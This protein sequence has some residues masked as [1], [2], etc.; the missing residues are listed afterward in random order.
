MYMYTKSLLWNIHQNTKNIHQE[1]QLAPENPHQNYSNNTK[2][3]VICIIIWIY[4]VNKIL[5][6]I[7]V[8][9][10]VHSFIWI[11]RASN[12]TLLQYY[13]YYYWVTSVVSNSVQPHRRQPTRLLCPWDFPGKSTG[14]GC[15]CLFHTIAI[16]LTII[17][18]NRSSVGLPRNGAQMTFWA[19]GNFL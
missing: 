7:E 19:G 11:S 1:H 10:N 6:E 16:D 14:V 4:L 3:N 13:Y 9:K 8:I 15:R 5:H 2:I 17:I 18:S 12:S